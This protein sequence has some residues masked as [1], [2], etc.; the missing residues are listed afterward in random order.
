MNAR[1]EHPVERPV[2]TLPE[3][4]AAW[5]GEEYARA[6]TI[7][8]YGS[9]GSTAMAAEMEGKRVIAVESDPAWLAAMERW[10][11][12]NPP[13]ADLT[14]HFADIGRVKEWGWPADAR[15][16]KKFPG[17]A[18]SV[19]DRAD[20]AHP[21][22]VLVDGRFRCGCL[23]ATLFRIRRPVRVLF[24]DYLSRSRYS[25]VEDFVR[26]TETRGRMARFDLAP[27]AVPAERLAQILSLISRPM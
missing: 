25:E 21:D 9:G 1:T 17:Y 23:L 14:L 6:S 3:A 13:R 26:P 2:L 5:V 22:L 4:E 20:F 11:A 15:S 12:Q 8:E 18:L 24:D 10:F 27:T 16:W 7:L 19:W